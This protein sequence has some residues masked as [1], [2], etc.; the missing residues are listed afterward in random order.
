MSSDRVDHLDEDPL[1]H[2]WHP[3]SWASAIADAPVATMLLGERLVIWRT[4]DGTVRVAAD[5]CPHRGTAL[6]LGCVAGDRLVCPYH[7]WEYA[8]DGACVKI[9]QSAPGAAIPARARLT[10]HRCEE[11]YGLVWVALDEPVSGI[12]AFAEF[13]DPAYR[14]VECPAY[15]WASSAPRMVENFT[16]FGHLGWLHDG[17]LGTRDDLVVPAH[18]VDDSGGELRYQLTMNVPNTNAELAVTD[19]RGERGT[20]TNTYVLTLPHTI[21]LQC[22]YH[23]TGA[24]RTLYFVAQPRTAT[25]STGYCFQSRD[26]QLDGDDQAFA[27]FQDLLAAQDRPIVESQ[28][29]AE[30]PLLLSDELHLPFD[31]VAVA[32]RR[33]LQRLEARR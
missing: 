33:A 15:T 2:Y 9:P 31:R 29:P 32:Y 24:H 20:Q 16:D 18:T 26:F 7:G 22:T 6:S 4:S 21:W 13:D 11:R 8:A 19:L 30:L 17:Y 3:V 10:P 14:H 5:R 25:E 28:Q 1:R 27:D 12:P 23:D